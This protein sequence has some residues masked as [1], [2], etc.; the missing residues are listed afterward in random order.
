[1]ELS[2]KT[3]SKKV[4]TK[5]IKF[6]KAVSEI[7]GR[8]LEY[9]VLVKEL[10]T[11]SSKGLVTQGLSD[12]AIYDKKTEFV[13]PHKVLNQGLNW[14]LYSKVYNNVGIVKNAVDNTTNFAIQSGYNF[15]PADDRIAEWANN[16]NLDALMSN[17]LTQLQIYGNAYLEITDIDSPKL[18]PV[19][20]MFVVV[21][22]AKNHDGE[23]LGYV[24]ITQDKFDLKNAPRWTPDEIIHFKYGEVGTSFYGMPSIRAGLTSIQYM[25][26]YQTD[27]G[28]ILHR[29]GNPKIHWRVGSDDD[30]TD[31]TANITAVKT[32]LDSA[33]VGHDI[34]TSAAVNAEVLLANL[35][36]IQ[37]DGLL[38]LMENQVISALQVPD[39]FVRGGES[40]NRSTA[41]VMLQAFDRKVK[42]LRNFMGKVIEKGIFKKQFNSDVKFAWRELS[43]EGEL[44]RSEILKNL[45]SSTGV[46][47][48]IPVGMDIA[49]YGSW[50]DDF[51]VEFDKD[52]QRKKKLADAM[53]KPAG[54]MN[55]GKPTSKSTGNPGQKPKSPNPGKESME[56]D[57]DDFDDQVSYL[58]ALELYKKGLKG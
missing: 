52:I 10:I 39:F 38:K 34:I 25:L 26:Q 6:P 31:Q 18:L 55:T 37:P 16:V 27:I 12:T 13:V 33:Q 3:G 1:M 56:P 29:Y 44:T 48:P 15:D 23:I 35:N 47:L 40:S 8:K 51:E 49:G 22:K 19:E 4:E 2:L 43:T 45:C 32:Q 46:G 21:S 17:I 57:E 54:A 36:M 14:D 53:P 42:A 9:P 24:Q 7:A 41:D 20:S 5:E 50:I 11:E 30:P 58:K 28:E